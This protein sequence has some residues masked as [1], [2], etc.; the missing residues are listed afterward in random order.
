MNLDWDVQKLQ[1]LMLAVAGMNGKSTA[2]GLIERM[3][4]HNGRRTVVCGGEARSLSS[5]AE[6]SGELDY[7]VFQLDAPEML[8]AQALRPAVAVLL[9]LDAARGDQYLRRYAALFRNQQFFDW[10]IVQSQ[11]L[12][13]L[14]EL[15]VALPAKVISFSAIDSHADLFLDHGLLVSRLPNWSG[16]LL[17]LEHCLLR[18]QHNA[19]NLMA[20]LAV[21]HVLRL[22]LEDMLDAVK[23][24][25]AGPHRCELIA[26]FNGV[27]F[28]NDS[29]A[30]NIEAMQCAVSATYAGVNNQPNVWLIAGG[31]DSAQDFHAAGPLISKRVKAAFLIG[32]ADQKIRSAWGLFTPCKRVASLLEAVAEAASNATSGDVVLLSPACSGLDQFRNYQHRGQIFCD[33]VKSIGRGQL[34]PRPHMS[35]VPAP[36]LV[37]TRR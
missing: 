26:E 36:S 25:Q 4:V 14:R 34:A 19:E 13:R 7:L 11:A 24:F 16:P 2:A 21:G 3:L 18:G 33:A 37:V 15:S 29:K 8:D 32:E 6:M 20:A 17:D 9:N 30:S 31:Q 1:C 35:G 28:V 23:T 10:A 22:P 12:A 5:G 27:Q